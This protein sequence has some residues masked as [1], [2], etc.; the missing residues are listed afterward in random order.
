[1]KIYN[2]FREPLVI[3]VTQQQLQL[4]AEDS[5]KSV[6]CPIY[7]NAIKAAVYLCLR[8]DLEITWHGGHDVEVKCP[9]WWQRQW[10]DTKR[11]F[12]SSA[13][14]AGLGQNGVAVTNLRYSMDG[15]FGTSDTVM[16]HQGGLSMSFFTGL[17]IETEPGFG[18]LILPP[19]NRFE[20]AWSVQAGYY[21]SDVFPGDFSFNFQILQQRTIKI[22]DQTP[23]CS[24][25]P[26][27]LGD[28]EFEVPTEEQHLER[29]SN[30]I[31]WN[32]IKDQSGSVD[33]PFQAILK[34]YAS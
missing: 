5:N 16:L 19:I 2:Y 18:A 12:V 21:N 30:S 4:Q 8:G 7:R 10:Q 1:M 17:S 31:R 25:I 22:P 32:R 9:D 29:W 6:R 33:K 14:E 27:R 23:V 15:P 11:F 13:M 3:P 26:V 24:I 28:P 20:S 34:E